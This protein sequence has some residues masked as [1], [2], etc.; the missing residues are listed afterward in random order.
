MRQSSEVGLTMPAPEAIATVSVPS[1]DVL[2]GILREGAQRLLAR[3]IDAEVDDWISRH[4][5]HAAD[6]GLAG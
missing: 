5:D 6:D 4:D 3:A 1:R 2:T